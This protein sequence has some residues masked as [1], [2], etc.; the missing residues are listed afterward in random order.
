M[1]RVLVQQLHQQNQCVKTYNVK[2]WGLE[3]VCHLAVSYCLIVEY[4]LIIPL[5]NKSNCCGC[6]PY[7]DPNILAKIAGM[8]YRLCLTEISW[9]VS[10]FYFH[11][12]LRVI[13][14]LLSIAVTRLGVFSR[15]KDGEQMNKLP[16][17]N[18]GEYVINPDD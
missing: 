15:D 2:I 17:T 1:A 13:L 14:R 12:I 18:D 6:L 9:N 3:I 16:R 4:F 11:S 10:Y 8:C 7:H 5:A